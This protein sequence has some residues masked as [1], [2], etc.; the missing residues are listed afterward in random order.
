MWQANACGADIVFFDEIRGMKSVSSMTAPADQLLWALGCIM[1]DGFQVM[2]SPFP[3]PAAGSVNITQMLLP[4]LVSMKSSFGMHAKSIDVIIDDRTFELDG[5]SVPSAVPGVFADR[6][7]LKDPVRNAGLMFILAYLSQA[8]PIEPGSNII[9]ILFQI[10]LAGNPSVHAMEMV[11]YQDGRPA[12]IMV[13]G[14]D[15]CILPRDAILHLW[16]N[17]RRGGRDG[18]GDPNRHPIGLRGR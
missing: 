17:A 6:P 18:R 13:H 1:D 7:E 14:Q 8:V 5:Q 10:L 2:W 12:R 15:G 16:Q 3:A 9:E 11:V 4:L